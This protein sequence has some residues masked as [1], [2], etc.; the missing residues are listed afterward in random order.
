M[1]DLRP[2]RRGLIRL[3]GEVLRGMSWPVLLTLFSCAGLGTA[4]IYFATTVD[5]DIPLTRTGYLALSI[6][7]TATLV[8][9]IAL[10]SLMFFSSRQGYDDP[11]DM[12][13]E[14]RDVSRPNRNPDN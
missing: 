1:R 13:A 9:G 3:Q 4:G 5:D 11:L 2:I 12:H 7:V 14:E 10:M 6:G 8:V